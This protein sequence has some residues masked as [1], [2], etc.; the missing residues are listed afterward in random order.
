MAVGL[1][2]VSG[3]VL[4]VLCRVRVVT[5]GKVRVMRSRLVVA[6]GVVPGGFAVM[7]RSVLVVLRCLRVMMSG[8]LG[9][10]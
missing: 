10:M 4:G 2:V 7:A 1:D 8:L 6:L 5:V 9:H 3:G